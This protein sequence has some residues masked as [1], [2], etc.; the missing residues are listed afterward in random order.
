MRQA[1]LANVEI[2]S[3]LRWK[4]LY[5]VVIKYRYFKAGVFMGVEFPPSPQ[6]TITTPPKTIAYE[7]ICH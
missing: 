1:L 2:L 4:Y 3:Q 5:Q 7:A 6:N